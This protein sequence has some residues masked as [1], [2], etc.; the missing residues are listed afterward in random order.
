MKNKLSLAFMILGVVFLL[1]FVSPYH[2]SGCILHPDGTPRMCWDLSSEGEAWGR[3]I[4]FMTPL[5]FI[6]SK[7]NPM[8]K[9]EKAIKG[10]LTDPAIGS[11]V[12]KM[13]PGLGTTVD[14]LDRL[15]KGAKKRRGMDMDCK[16]QRM[17]MQPE[18]EAI[19]FSKPY[20]KLDFPVWFHTVRWMDK[21]YRLGN[22]YKIL[23]KDAT[24][25][26]TKGHARCF[27]LELK[28]LE[29]LGMEFILRD[30]DCT[31]AEFFQMME[32]WYK[33]KPDWKDKDSLVQVVYLEWVKEGA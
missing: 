7:E 12:R 26:F 10:V 25:I 1:A 20:K 5:L 29:D 32:S 17:G 18:R 33:K 27:K 14:V 21:D 28:R 23:V 24:G 11:L 15:E 3:Y 6:V 19:M 31:P 13:I 2:H 16:S 9:T 30:A 22:V 8:K 4:D